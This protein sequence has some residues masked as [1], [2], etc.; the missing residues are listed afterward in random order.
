MEVSIR[1]ISKNRLFSEVYQSRCPSKRFTIQVLLFLEKDPDCS[2]KIDPPAPGSLDNV[3]FI[4]RGKCLAMLISTLSARFDS[5]RREVQYPCSKV[6]GYTIPVVNQYP[7]D[8]ALLLHLFLL[9]LNPLSVTPGSWS[10]PP[11]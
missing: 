3:N 1:G 2:R 8:R 11:G 7:P 6:T 9:S 4:G 10:L 5:W